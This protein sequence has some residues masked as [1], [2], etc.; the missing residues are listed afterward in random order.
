MNNSAISAMVSLTSM[1]NRLDVIADNI[2]NLD[3]NG[4]KR[5]ESSFEDTLTRVQNQGKDFKQPG[6]V[7]PLGYNLGF[8]VRLASVTMNME[9]GALQETGIPT[10][11]AIEGNALFAVESNGNT[12]YTREGA[13]HF[14]PDPADGDYM[15]LV[16][17]QGDRVLNNDDPSVPVRVLAN[18]K[19]AIDSTGNVWTTLHGSTTARITNSL[20]IVEPQKP[21]GL[22]QLSDNLFT[23]AA[24][25][26]TDE[27]FGAGSP[28]PTRG[29]NP[30]VAIRSGFLEKSNVDLTTEMADMVQVQRAYQMV[31]RTLSSSDTL[32]NLANNMR[33]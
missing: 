16:N 24:G 8:G 9:Q 17:N 22:V 3:N 32:M 18:S 19:V 20:R 23:L 13:F 14:V 5:K 33:G 21:E 2:A 25:L 7:T 1:Q 31:A 10:D 11:L 26:T 12:A 28:S 4:Y 30:Q 15:L 27:V 6:R 29:D